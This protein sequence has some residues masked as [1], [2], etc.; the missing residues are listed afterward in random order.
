MAVATE[1]LR[2][3]LYFDSSL[4]ALLTGV[5]FSADRAQTPFRPMGSY[6]PTQILKGRRNY[7]GGA[8]KAYVCG[9]WMG[10]FQPTIRITGRLSTPLAQRP[11][12]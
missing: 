7:E 11:V 12:G 6:D 8:R 1:G 5:D 3:L 2:A 4:V 10:S 9:D